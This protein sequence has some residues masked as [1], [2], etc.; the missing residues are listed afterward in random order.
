MKRLGPLVA[1]G[2]MLGG[3]FATPAMA[4]PYGHSGLRQE[5]RAQRIKI[6]QLLVERDA[7]VQE[8]V[9]LRRQL[10]RSPTPAQ[11]ADAQAQISSLQIALAEAQETAGRRRNRIRGLKAELDEANARIFRLRR[12]LG[13]RASVRHAPP[14]RSPRYYGAPPVARVD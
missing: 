7:A 13:L 4:G 2:L 3:L 9:Q 6:E 10:Q 12:R 5:V 1:L 11:W 8:A 14:S